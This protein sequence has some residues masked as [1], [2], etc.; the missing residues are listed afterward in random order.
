MNSKHENSD[1]RERMAMGWNE[2]PDLPGVPGQLARA[3]H[4]FRKATQ[5]FPPAGIGAGVGIG[6]GCGFGWPLRAAYG[7]PR[8]MCGASIGVGIGIG[9][10]QGFGKRFG[11]DNRPRGLRTWFSNVENALDS[12]AS[13]AWKWIRSLGRSAKSN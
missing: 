13:A 4:A 1:R 9:Y 8:A 5:I 6:L 10:G 11:S 3:A 12:G 2:P 7:P